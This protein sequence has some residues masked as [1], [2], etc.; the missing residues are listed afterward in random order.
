MTASWGTLPVPSNQEIH[1]FGLPRYFAGS[2]AFNTDGY[3]QVPEDDNPV[4]SYRTT[5]TL[6]PEWEHSQVFVTFDGVDSAFY[7]WV[8]GEIVGYSV[9]SRLP[10][11]FNLTPFLH[12]GENNLAVRVHRWSCG[13]YLEDQDMWFLSGIFRDVYLSATPPVHVR[14]FW[15]Q[16]ELDSNYENAFVSLQVKLKNYGQ[17]MSGAYRVEANLY[18]PR[19]DSR[20]GLGAGENSRGEG[21]RRDRAGDGRD[22][23]PAIKVVGGT[24]APVHTALETE[25]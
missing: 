24:T 6:P 1:G 9:D 15:V 23:V 21:R 25:R 8:N 20:S 14:D 17:N 11:E 12:P 2:Y 5:F 7:L 3:P 10:A 18:A 16:T 13:S 4:G 22:G 19:P